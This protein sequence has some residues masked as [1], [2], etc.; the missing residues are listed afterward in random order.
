MTARRRSTGLAKH[1][2]VRGIPDDVA[3][4]LAQR[5]R[6]GASVNGTVILLLRQAL[7]LT[8]GAPEYDNGL[9]R[10]AGTWTVRE[11]EA[12]ERATEPFEAIDEELW[13]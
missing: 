12:F 1:L 7:G 13:R 3:N 5:R 6:G 2:T 8:H 11:H 4:A 10:L 9:G